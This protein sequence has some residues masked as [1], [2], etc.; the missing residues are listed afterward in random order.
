MLMNKH[1]IRI[2]AQAFYG[3]RTATEVERGEIDRFVLGYLDK[4]IFVDDARIDRTI[5]KVPNTDNIVI[6]YNKYEEEEAREN[7]MLKPLI[8]IPED[9]IEI[10]SRCVI[11]RVDENGEFEDLR[12]EDFE[13]F[14]E[15]LAE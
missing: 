14:I 3:N 4:N 1:L 6:V 15:F 10:Y 7:K 13:K 2:M 12:K 9:N 8:V 11:C 5:I